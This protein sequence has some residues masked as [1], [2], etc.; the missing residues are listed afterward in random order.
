MCN[1][2]GGASSHQVLQC[3]LHQPLGL[4]IE[5]GRCLIEDQDRRISNGG[6]GDRK[7]LALSLA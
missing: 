5:S 7:Q 3:L 1:D 2:D 4:G 6:T